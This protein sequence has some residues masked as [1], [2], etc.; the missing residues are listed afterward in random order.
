MTATVGRFCPMLHVFGRDQITQSQ[1]AAF[2][3]LY[4]CIFV[5]D[6]GLTLIWGH[7]MKAEKLLDLLILYIFQN[8][9]Y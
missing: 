6:D 9:A 1:A 3:Q 8:L 4:F 2:L 5:R 7:N